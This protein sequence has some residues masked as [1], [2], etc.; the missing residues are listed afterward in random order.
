MP[1]EEDEDDE[2]DGLE[3]VLVL[4]ESVLL[5]PVSEAGFDSAGFDSPVFDPL[6]SDTLFLPEP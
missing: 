1:E 5:L 2:V 3:S 4:L 6:P